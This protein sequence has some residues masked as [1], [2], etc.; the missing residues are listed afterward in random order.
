MSSIAASTPS[1]A[2]PAPRSVVA[3]GAAVATY[4]AWGLLPAYWKILRELPA[5]EVMCQRMAWSAL[6]MAVLVTATGQW[7]TVGQ[8]MRQRRNVV[9][10]TLSAALIG[11]NWWLYIWAVQQN[12][13]LEAS[14]G[15]FIN[16]LFNVAIGTALL[17]EP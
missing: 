3:V 10:F 6:F 14:L 8:A 5:A 17:R 7:A 12:R 15:Y 16:P 4:T 9:S 13:V 11:S 1:S 2:K